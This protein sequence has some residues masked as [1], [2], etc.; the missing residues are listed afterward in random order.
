[1]NHCYIA[2][3]TLRLKEFL[4]RGHL[5]KIVFESNR[6]YIY[7]YFLENFNEIKEMV[8]SCDMI[9]KYDTYTLQ[10]YNEIY[11]TQIQFYIMIKITDFF[12]PGSGLNCALMSGIEMIS[13]I[14]L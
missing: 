11:Q 12:N 8:N 1:M 6:N 4:N 9:H 13:K 10:Y 14:K 3:T 7:T 5:S 2:M